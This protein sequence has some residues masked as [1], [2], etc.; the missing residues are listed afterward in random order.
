MRTLK[1]FIDGIFYINMDQNVDRKKSIEKVLSNLNL[2]SISQRIPGVTCNEEMVPKWFRGFKNQ[3]KHKALG[4]TLAHL[5]CYQLAKR[6]NFKRFLIFEDDFQITNY[7]LF[8]EYINKCP[9]YDIIYLSRSFA[10]ATMRRNEVIEEIICGQLTTTGYIVHRRHLNHLIGMCNPMIKR[11]RHPKSGGGSIDQ[12]LMY[13]INIKKCRPVKEI[14]KCQNFES[15][16]TK[17]S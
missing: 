13:E 8:N 5:H 7:D 11:K 3:I 2:L 12:V 17:P 6:A 14:S 15:N 16:I 10:R 1:P 4:C 9:D